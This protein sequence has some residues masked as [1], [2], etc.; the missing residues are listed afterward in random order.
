MG[1][2]A[3]SADSRSGRCHGRSP[4]AAAV[5]RRGGRA[6]YIGPA[7]AVAGI[8]SEVPMLT[9]A[10]QTLATAAETPVNGACGAAA[11]ATTIEFSAIR[12]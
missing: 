12:R 1:V 7:F 6:A 11:A 4:G 10:V 9:A 8:D 3:A 2:G 5:S